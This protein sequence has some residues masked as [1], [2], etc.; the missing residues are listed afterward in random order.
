MTTKSV[1]ELI[2]QLNEHLEASKKLVRLIWNKHEYEIKFT[3]IKYGVLIQDVCNKDSIVK[4]SNFE[5]KWKF[6]RNQNSFHNFQIANKSD[7]EKLHKRL[8]FRGVKRLNNKPQNNSSL[9]TR[10]L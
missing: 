5:S 8:D 4:S 9:S 7:Y 3:D 1:S 10:K 6:N 2:E